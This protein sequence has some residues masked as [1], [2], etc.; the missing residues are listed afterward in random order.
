[1]VGEAIGKRGNYSGGNYTGYYRNN[2]NGTREESSWFKG[3]CYKCREEGHRAFECTNFGKKIGGKNR[4][5]LAC[6]EVDEISNKPEKDEN[7]MVRRVLWNEEIDEEIVLRRN[8]FKTRYKIAGKYFKVINDSGSSN[9]LSSEE[10][11]NKLQL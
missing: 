3:T 9:N 2:N 8:L 4:N 7:L 11:V 6:E 5:T 1:M 10:F